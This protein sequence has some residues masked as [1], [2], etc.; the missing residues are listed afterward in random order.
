MALHIQEFSGIAGGIQIPMQPPIAGTTAGLVADGEY[1]FIG[2]G[3]GASVGELYSAGAAHTYTVSGATGTPL[4]QH[5]AS[6]ERLN[7]AFSAG[8]ILTVES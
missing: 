3:G 2:A 1:T 6:G 8:A 5:I 4:V 7:Y